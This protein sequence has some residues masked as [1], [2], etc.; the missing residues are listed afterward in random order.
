MGLEKEGLLGGSWALY[1][2][3]LPS[4]LKSAQESPSGG[5]SDLLGRGS[6]KPTP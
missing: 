2:L 5:A 4:L 1:P 6:L 3:Q